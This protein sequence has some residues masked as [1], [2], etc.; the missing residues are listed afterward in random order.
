M[1]HRASHHCKQVLLEGLGLWNSLRKVHLLHKPLQLFIE[2]LDKGQ[3]PS[4]H[5]ARI[6]LLLVPLSVLGVQ[7]DVVHNGECDQDGSGAVVML[8]PLGLATGVQPHQPVVEHKHSLDVPLT[9]RASGAR[10]GFRLH[11]VLT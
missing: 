6:Q 9:D 8:L 4:Q 7:S 3:A 1:G 2:G 5:V 10:G 11:Q